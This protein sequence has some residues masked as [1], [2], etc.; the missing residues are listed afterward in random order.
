MTNR[1]L[2][3]VQRPANAYHLSVFYQFSGAMGPSCV[4]C[5]DDGTLY[6]GLYD[7]AGRARMHFEVSK[8]GLTTLVDRSL[9]V[10]SR[11]RAFARGRAR[12]RVRRSGSR[13]HGHL[14]QVSVA[15]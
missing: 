8:R 2:R 13:D 9:A 12:A 6:V 3:L 15:C 4:T 7:F 10:W 11:G 14:R 1:L 5:A